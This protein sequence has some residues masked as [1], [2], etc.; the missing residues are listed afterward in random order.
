MHCAD[1]HGYTMAD[2][3]IDQIKCTIKLT[4]LEIYYVYSCLGR[5][6]LEHFQK[7]DPAAKSKKA[8]KIRKI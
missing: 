1:D 3:G 6:T 2:A 5:T 8:H 7:F 4:H